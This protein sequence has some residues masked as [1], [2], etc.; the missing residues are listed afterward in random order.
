M[1]IILVVLTVSFG[2]VLPSFAADTPPVGD[3]PPTEIYGPPN[4]ATAQQAP[5]AGTAGYK[6]GGSVQLTN[7][8]GSVTP[9]EII[10][11][12]ITALLGLTGVLALIAFIYG[13]VLWMISFG[14]PGKVEKGKKMMIWAVIGLVVVFS[15][16]AVLT[17]VFQAFGFT[18]TG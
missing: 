11:N 18:A 4:P 12:I 14:D 8:L 2:M 6:A 9:L 15:S 13:G 5:G 16:Y 17:L 10:N 1:L 3:T 7:P